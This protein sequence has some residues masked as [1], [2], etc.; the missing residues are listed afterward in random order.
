MERPFQA[1]A[2][3]KFMQQMLIEGGLVEY[4]K[5]VE[6]FHVLKLEIDKIHS[7]E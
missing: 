2:V 1:K 5:N 3:P 7:K 6:G 4:Y